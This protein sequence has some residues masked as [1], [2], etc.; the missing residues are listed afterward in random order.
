MTL[1]E[2]KA[3]F[4]GFTE[5]MDGA[6]APELW[7]RGDYGKVLEYVAQDVRTTLD[8]AYAVDREKWL[9]W[10]SKSNAPVTVRV[11]KWLS[12]VEAL[13]LPLPDVSWMGGKEWK[14]DK[15]VWWINA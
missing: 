13:D 1:S 8:V 10:T 14:R 11:E 4:E 7:R 3:W 9:R 6:K 5:G 15:F 12:V 2:F